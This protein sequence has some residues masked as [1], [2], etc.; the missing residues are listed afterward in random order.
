MPVHDAVARDGERVRRNLPREADAQGHVW[1][2]QPEQ[3]RDSVAG[4]GHHDVDLA[5]RSRDEL[6]HLRVAR[7]VV[8]HA[9]ERNRLMACFAQERR[10]PLDGRGHLGYEDD[11]HALA[12]LEETHPLPVGDDL[13]EERLLG[14]GVVQVMVD[15]LV[16]ERLARH[17]AELQ[18][19]DRLPQ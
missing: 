18:G 13:V 4:R 1:L 17:R 14:V 12:A 7:R 8:A 5:R 6:A 19:E 2:E 9:E 10:E 3:R 11:A 15:H 16:A